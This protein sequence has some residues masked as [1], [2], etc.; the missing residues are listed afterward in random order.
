MALI[1]ELV[2]E[3]ARAEGQR[4]ARVLLL[5]DALDDIPEDTSEK[6][7]RLADMKSNAAGG[8]YDAQA[9]WIGAIKD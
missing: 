8:N 3:I 2:A 4:G 1:D 7:S 6:Q 9:R 5:K